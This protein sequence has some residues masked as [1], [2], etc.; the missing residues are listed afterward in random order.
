MIEEPD[1]P[2]PVFEIRFKTG[3]YEI[4]EEKSIGLEDLYRTVIDNPGQAILIEGHTDNVFTEE[5]NQVLS[6]RRAEALKAFF[7]NK[8]IPEERIITRGYGETRPIANNE[9]EEGRA[10]NRRVEVFLIDR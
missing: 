7:V 5:Y 1:E 4:D 10:K 3:S 6:E 2:D 9:T 8:G